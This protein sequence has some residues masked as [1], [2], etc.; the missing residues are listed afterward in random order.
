MLR[1]NIKRSEIILV[2]ITILLLNSCTSVGNNSE[3]KVNHTETNS[4]L[5]SPSNYESNVFIDIDGDRDTITELFAGSDIN[6]VIKRTNNVRMYYQQGRWEMQ[7]LGNYPGWALSWLLF[8]DS[9]WSK[10]DNNLWYNENSKLYLKRINNRNLIVSND[11]SYKFAQT[12]LLV[13]AH[14]PVGLG[15]ENAKWILQY[16]VDSIIGSLGMMP[17]FNNSVSF[18]AFGNGL[19]MPTTQSIWIEF[20]TEKQASGAKTLA[21][22]ALPSILELFNFAKVSEEG[23]KYSVKDNFLIIAGVDIDF[24]TITDSLFKQ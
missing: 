17:L 13:E 3:L 4:F 19:A 6:K 16:N 24:I 8:W 12:G 21:R 15:V 10:T 11:V 7:L 1:K 14:T 9:Q 23:I 18:G 5:L 2:A 22:I 20:K